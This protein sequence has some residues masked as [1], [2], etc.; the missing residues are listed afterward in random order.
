MLRCF[1]LNFS[2]LLAVENPELVKDIDTAPAGSYFEGA[3]AVGERLFFST[4]DAL[5][6]SDG[7][8][9]GTLQISGE[10]EPSQL[11]GVGD[12]VYFTSR[13][14]QV[15]W[16]SDGTSPGTRRIGV[17]PDVLLLSPVGIRLLF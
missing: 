5:W 11:T 8:A 1:L 12:K 17:F 16:V 6:V 7:T 2:I 10:H 14:R 9:G 13:D 15:L 4:V 3:T